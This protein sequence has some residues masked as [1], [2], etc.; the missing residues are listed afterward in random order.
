MA[1]YKVLS[2]R[3]PFASLLVSGVKDVENRSRRTNFRGTV[4]IHASARMHDV[5]EKLSGYLQN[6][7]P[8]IG[9]EKDI[10]SCANI[11]DGFNMFSCIIGSVDIVDCVQNHPSRWAEEGQWHWVCANA[12]MFDHP[13]RN[14]KGKLGIWEWEGEINNQNEEQKWQRSRNRYRPTLCG[15]WLIWL[16]SMPS[17]RMRCGGSYI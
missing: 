1:K 10:M 9:I 12:R 6:G 13:I 2:V 14:V 15:M 5:V 17:S 4:L 3:Q 8:L 16:A 7:S 11:A